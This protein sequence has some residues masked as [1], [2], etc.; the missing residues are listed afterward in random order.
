[1]ISPPGRKHSAIP[2][3]EGPSAFAT[4]PAVSGEPVSIVRLIVCWPFASSDTWSE[5][6]VQVAARG[7]PTHP[8]ERIHPHRKTT[9]HSTSRQSLLVVLCYRS[10]T[11]SS[12]KSL[13]LATH[14]RRPPARPHQQKSPVLQK[15][16]RLPFDRV[17]HKLQQPPKAKQ[18]DSHPQ[19]SVPHHRR[20]QHRQRQH[21][22]RNPKRVCQP[23]Q[24]ML[25]TL[26]ILR[27]PALPTSST[28]HGDTILSPLHHPQPKSSKQP[29]DCL[30]PASAI[31]PTT[32]SSQASQAKQRIEEQSPAWPRSGSRI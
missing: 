28:K 19:Q 8:T 13:G 26:R 25:M 20:Q 18:P 16:R 6:N 27:D 32:P 10:L 14:L 29:P 2:P 31:Q 21:N 15:L 24:R 12:A 1:M 30:S 5:V 3:A 17:P 7:R 23:V 22:N 9:G 11:T 4:L